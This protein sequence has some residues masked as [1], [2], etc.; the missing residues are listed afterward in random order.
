MLCLKLFGQ[1]GRAGR[2]GA[3]GDALLFLLPSE[4]DY[5]NVLAEHRVHPERLQFQDL[6]IALNAF[7]D[8]GNAEKSASHLQYHIEKAVEKEKEAGL[9]ARNGFRSRIRAYATYPANVKHIFHVRRLHLGHMAKSFGLRE[10]PSI[11]GKKTSVEMK[12][13]KIK[14]GSNK[15]KEREGKGVQGGKGGKGFERAEKKPKTLQSMAAL[16]HSKV[17]EFG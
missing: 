8:C 9:L 6:L 16:L 15:R 5:V 3:A 13:N 1:V 2:L 12:A 7:S 17:S 10:Q 4:A 11:T 14:V